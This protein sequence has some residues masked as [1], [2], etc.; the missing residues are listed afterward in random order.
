MKCT[1]NKK[2]KR[3]CVKCPLWSCL[4]NVQC[5]LLLITALALTELVAAC[6]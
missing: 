4:Y 6:V 1:E 2:L 5:E 3:V